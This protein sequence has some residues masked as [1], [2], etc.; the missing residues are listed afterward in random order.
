[1]ELISM[2]AQTAADNGGGAVA[3]GGGLVCM[4]LWIGILIASVVLWIWALVDAVKNP[5]LDGNTRLIWVLVIIFVPTLGAILYLVV[6]RK[7]T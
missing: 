7:G 2:L 1:M 5:A 3:L 6:G 4:L